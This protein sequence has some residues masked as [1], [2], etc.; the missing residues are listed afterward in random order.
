LAEKNAKSF[1]GR[2][3]HVNVDGNFEGMA[4]AGVDMEKHSSV[5]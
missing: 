3:N 4:A 2:K 5:I 1:F